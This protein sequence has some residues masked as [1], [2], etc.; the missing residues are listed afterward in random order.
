MEE[1]R[2]LSS[3]LSQFLQQS[4]LN[5]YNSTL[6]GLSYKTASISQCNRVFNFS[7][8]ESR[9]NVL[10][11]TQHLHAVKAD[12]S[13]SE[14]TNLLIISLPIW[15]YKGM[16]ILTQ[17]DEPRNSE[18]KKWAKRTSSNVLPNILKL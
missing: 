17:R 3:T 11:F 16:N 12:R 18:K 7:S 6:L 2:K 8:L 10:R 13:L 5:F 14:A 9:R 15:T 4:D 1:L